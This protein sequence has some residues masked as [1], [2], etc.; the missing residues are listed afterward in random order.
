MEI[1]LRVMLCLFYLWGQD[2][3]VVS[4]GSVLFMC[5]EP[6]FVSYSGMSVLK[7]LYISLL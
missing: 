7:L 6:C 3:C 5:D 2:L 4:F 1:Y